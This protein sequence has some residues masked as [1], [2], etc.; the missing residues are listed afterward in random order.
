MGSEMDSDRR[1]LAPSKLRVWAASVV[2]ALTALAAGPFLVA[3][4]CYWQGAQ[5]WDPSGLFAA[6][7]QPG[8]APYHAA[9]LALFAAWAACWFLHLLRVRRHGRNML[10]ASAPM[11][12]FVA[13]ALHGSVM[14]Y[15]CN[16]I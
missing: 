7:F 15:P 11:V 5:R 9:A 4:V 2:L 8:V 16:P 12:V 3:P 14:S 10:H 6:A 13:A 1:T